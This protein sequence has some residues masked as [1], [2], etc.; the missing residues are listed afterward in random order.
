MDW[1]S[2]FLRRVETLPLGRREGWRKG[3]RCPVCMQ[4]NTAGVQS[5]FIPALPL[6]PGCRR[7]SKPGQN[8]ADWKRYLQI[9]SSAIVKGG[10]GPGRESIPMRQEPG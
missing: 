6:Q 8:Q 9:R 1:K 3:K 7:R 10:L 4:R 5:E 2:V